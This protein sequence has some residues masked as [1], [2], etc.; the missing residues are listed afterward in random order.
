M[1]GAAY[2]VCSLDS[3]SDSSAVVKA[4]YAFN[5]AEY[6]VHEY[7]TTLC[8]C[9]ASSQSAACKCGREGKRRVWARSAAAVNVLAV[10]RSNQTRGR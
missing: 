3:D 8:R 4:Q 10:V 2:V 7:R 9:T 5:P 6:F 1:R